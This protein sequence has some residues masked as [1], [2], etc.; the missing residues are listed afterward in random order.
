MVFRA[1]ETNPVNA[2]RL[3]G[4]RDVVRRANGTKWVRVAEPLPRIRFV[5]GPN[6]GDSSGPLGA[7]SPP[8]FASPLDTVG[9][10][11]GPAATSAD[12]NAAVE[13][14]T[15]DCQELLVKVGTRTGG[16]LIVAD[17]FYPAGRAWSMRLRRTS[18]ECSAAS[19][20]FGCQREAIWSECTF[21]ANRLSPAANC[22]PRDF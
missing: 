15:D 5:P 3:A 7:A 11:D 9:A 21:A 17:T 2:R 6:S 20:E 14:L 13:V 22:Q 1:L 4:G 12:T 18:S 19:A 8:D 16:M 10:A